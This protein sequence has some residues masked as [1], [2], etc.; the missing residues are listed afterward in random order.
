MP[1]V[2]VSL[3][4]HFFIPQINDW[5][6]IDYA[7]LG[8][9][10]CVY[11]YLIFLFKDLSQLTTKFT[12]AF[13]QCASYSSY[14]TNRTPIVTLDFSIILYAQEIRSLGRVAKSDFRF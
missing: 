6:F 1:A 2:I 3:A 5:R 12:A 7:F 11:N 4:F 14:L 9:V 8:C 10:R 13:G